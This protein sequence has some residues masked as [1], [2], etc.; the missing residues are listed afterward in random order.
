MTVESRTNSGEIRA[1]IAMPARRRPHALL[2][3]LRHPRGKLIKSAS[4]NGRNWEDFD[5]LGERV[6]IERPSR[7]EYDIVARY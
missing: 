7:E 5:I 3:R 4:V 2:V 1:A 6:R